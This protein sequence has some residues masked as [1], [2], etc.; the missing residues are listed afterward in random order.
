MGVDSADLLEWVRA[1]PRLKALKPVVCDL[2]GVFR[3]KRLPVS[4]AGLVASGGLKMPITTIFFDIWGRDV[5]SSGQVLE[6]G[7][8]DGK[9]K[10]T[11]RGP[12]AL[13]FRDGTQEALLPHVMC[14]SDGEPYEADPRNALARI[15]E[16]YQSKSLTPVCAVELEFYLYDPNSG[17]GTPSPPSPDNRLKSD[18]AAN[19][20]AIHELDAFEPFIDHIFEACEAFGIPAQTS[21]SESG[22]GQFEVNFNHTPDPMKAADDAVLF[23]YVVKRIA[24]KAGLGVTFMAKPYATDSGNG[25]HTHMSILDGKGRNIFSSGDDAGSDELQFAVNGLLEALPESMLVFAPHANSYRRL[26]IGSHAPANVSWGYDNR[27]VAVRIPAGSDA[28][29]RIEHRVA[30]ADANPY[31]VLS[32]ILGAALD[33][34]EQ[35]TRPIAPSTGNA[36]DGDGVRLPATWEAAIERFSQSERS[37]SVFGDLLVDV[38]SAGKRQELDTLARDIPSTEYRAYL[39]SV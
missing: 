21:M 32:S 36:Y 23:K 16:R 26:R 2:N 17:D 1:R 11:E 10:L 30:G 6:T 9:L 35:K 12:L 5:H 27:T 4:E 13:T 22:A 31:L 24:Q 38:Y 7:D 3:G 25:F 34:I 33:G 15:F 8:H 29:R 19:T 20:Y 37:R 39:T 18:P 28:S 14:L